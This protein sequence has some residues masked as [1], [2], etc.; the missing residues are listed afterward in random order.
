ME[1]CLEDDEIEVDADGFRR[2]SRAA[3]MRIGAEVL[4]LLAGFIPPTVAT[5]FSGDG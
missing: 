1:E 2:S 3:V 5:L 4:F